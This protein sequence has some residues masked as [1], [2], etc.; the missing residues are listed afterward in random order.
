MPRLRPLSPTAAGIAYICAGSF[1]LTVNDALAKYLDGFLPVMEIIFF[2]MLFALPLIIA[3]GLAVGGRQALATRAPWLQISRGVVAIAAPLAYITGLAVLPLAANAAI[4][5]ASPLFI[6]LLAVTVLGERPGW[7]QW[8]A[9]CV[10]FAGVRFVIQSGTV[11]FTWVAF[12]P[13]IAALAY[14]LLM[15]SARTL[16]NKGDSIWVIM[17]YATAVPLL[18]SALLLPRYWVTPAP[19]LWPALVG[20][21]LVGGEIGGASG[22]ARW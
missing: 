3:S 13:L 20:V 15:L 8:V 9:T 5:F 14:A 7:R 12:F 1:C 16:A 17:L 21:G 4:S 2:R 19:M 11:I 10:G 22:W 18:I 6:T